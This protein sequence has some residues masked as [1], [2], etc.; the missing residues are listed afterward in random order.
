MR[1]QR[2]VAGRA[3][4][5]L[6]AHWNLGQRGAGVVDHPAGD[7]AARR[8][9]E[10][11]RRGRRALAGLDGAHGRRGGV[12]ADGADRVLAGAQATEGKAAARA[13]D[14]LAQRPATVRREQDAR[15]RDGRPGR[16]DPPD[17]RS[18]FTVDADGGVVGGRR[19]RRL[20]G[21]RKACRLDQQP[22]GARRQV[23][24]AEPAFQVGRVSNG[25]AAVA[26]RARTRARAPRAPAASRRS[27]TL[28]PSQAVAPGPRPPSRAATGGVRWQRQPGLPS[29]TK[30]EQEARR[31]PPGA[32]LRFASASAKG[33]RLPEGFEMAA[34]CEVCGKQR[35]V[36]NNVSHSNIKTKSIQRPNLRRVHARLAER[37]AQPHPRLHPV[38]AHGSRSRRPSAALSAAL[39]AP[40][41]RRGLRLLVFQ[42]AALPRFARERR[43]ASRRARRGTAAGRRSRSSPD[44]SSGG[45]S[46]TSSPLR[47]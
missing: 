29:K 14:R 16:A 5:G 27:T 32:C 21:G 31:Q 38:P 35:R 34:H 12:A 26:P 40:R 11:D 7:G 42:A 4:V 22:I 45:S 33:T 47:S 1:G 24:E 25:V 39:V 28:P 2:V 44:R 8:Q 23:G 19:H 17:D 9:L 13:R 46:T 37:H 43:G 30:Q 6:D 3:R 41:R 20:L 18:P 15:A 10:L 36:A